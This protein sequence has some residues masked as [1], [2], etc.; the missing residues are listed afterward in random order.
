MTAWLTIEAVYGEVRQV[1]CRGEG[2][3]VEGAQGEGVAGVRGDRGG[4]EGVGD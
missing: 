1:C 2:T 4:E 3:T